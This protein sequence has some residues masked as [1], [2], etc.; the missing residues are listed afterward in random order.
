MVQCLSGG[1]TP[2]SI[3]DCMRHRA[4]MHVCW[5]CP[6]RRK[7][8]SKFSERFAAGRPRER[9]AACDEGPTGPG[10]GI[11]ETRKFLE[12]GFEAHERRKGDEGFGSQPEAYSSSSGAKYF[13]RSARGSRTPIRDPA[14]QPA[15]LMASDHTNGSSSRKLRVP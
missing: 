15:A 12:D 13:S 6:A 2:G 9:A 5:S 4:Q 10:T 14:M 11:M 1:R 8:K 7:S 3:T